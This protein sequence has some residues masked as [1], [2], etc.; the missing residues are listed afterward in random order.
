[1]G[2]G[3]CCLMGTE[4]CLGKHES[5]KALEMDGERAQCHRTEH[6]TVEMVNFILCVF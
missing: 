2:G 3:G 1:M 5:E 6:K 4:L